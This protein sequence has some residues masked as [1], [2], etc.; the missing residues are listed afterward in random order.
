MP[1]ILTHAPPTV[2]DL[3]HQVMQQ[4]RPELLEYKV[5]V[6]VLMAKYVDKS[7][8]IRRKSGIMLHGAAC[9]ACI[10]VNSYRERTQG[11]PD[12]TMEVCEWRWGQL[13]ENQKRAL[14]THEMEHPQLVV[15]KKTKAVKYDALGRPMLKN[16]PDDVNITGFE[17]VV[18]R[19]GKDALELQSVNSVARRWAP[20]INRSESKEPK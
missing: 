19:F 14:L 4:Y 6:G 20:L 15:D 7:G 11:S 8:S 2:M 3:L 10:R 13:T 1:R 9:A 16:R 12:C 17:I 18:E 5:K